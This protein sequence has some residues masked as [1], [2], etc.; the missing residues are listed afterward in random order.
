MNLVPKVN[1]PVGGLGILLDKAEVRGDVTFDAV[2]FVYPNRPESPVLQGFDLQVNAGQVVALVGPSGS[3]KSTVTAL[4][5]QHKSL[6]SRFPRPAMSPM[7]CSA[8]TILRHN[9]RSDPCRWSRRPGY[10]SRLLTHYCW[11]CCARASAIRNVN[12]REHSLW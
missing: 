11:N 6:A 4:V 8:R 1:T 3:G 5:R 2:K 10:P 12:P 9:R 7:C